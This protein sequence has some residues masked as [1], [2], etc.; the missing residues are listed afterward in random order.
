[1]NYTFLESSFEEKSKECEK[2]TNND[3]S[4]LNENEQQLILNV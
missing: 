3:I 2:L 1:L 4:I